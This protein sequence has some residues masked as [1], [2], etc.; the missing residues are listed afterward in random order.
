MSF[1]TFCFHVKIGPKEA[2]NRK[3]IPHICKIYEVTPLLW[4]YTILPK[5]LTASYLRKLFTTRQLSRLAAE[6]FKQ[7]PMILKIK[8]TTPS[9]S[10]IPESEKL[11]RKNSFGLTWT[12][13]LY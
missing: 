1:H 7:P 4:P 8:P 2:N 9:A 3:K 6:P 12:I 11:K 5:T 13:K 10:R